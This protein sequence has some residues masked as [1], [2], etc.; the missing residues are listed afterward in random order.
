MG[1]IHR[2]RNL[3]LYNPSG[4][5]LWHPETHGQ[6]PGYVVMRYD[7]NL[8]LVNTCGYVAWESRTAGDFNAYLVLHGDGNLVI[9]AE[10]QTTVLWQT[11][12]GG[13]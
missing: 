7:G 5:P 8:M 6:R 13:N 3:V 12:T 10:D 9:Y 2:H 4:S 11:R 1:H